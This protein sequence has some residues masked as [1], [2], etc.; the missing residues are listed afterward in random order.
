MKLKITLC[1]LILL[2]II[3]TTPAQTIATPPAVAAASGQGNTWVVSIG[4][5]K[6]EHAP[7]LQYTLADAKVFADA[8]SQ[9]GLVPESN[10][11]RI[12]DGLAA[13]EKASALTKLL[14]QRMQSAGTADTFI[15]FFAGHGFT[16]RD[17]TTYLAL[18]DFDPK[19][20]SETGLSTRQLR[21][22][23]D[24]CPARVK[25]VILDSCFSGGFSAADRIDGQAVVDQLKRARGTVAICSS[26]SKQESLEASDLGHGVFTYWLNR[27]LRGEANTEID[28][29]IDSA[30]LFRFVKDRVMKMASETQQH[31][32][33]PTWGFDQMAEIPTVIELRRPDKPSVL[34][35][36]KQMPIGSDEQSLSA[37]M[38]VLEKFPQANVR[39]TIGMTK[40]IIA[41]AS[42]SSSVAKRA[43]QHLDQL[44]A[45]LLN[46]TLRLPPPEP[47]E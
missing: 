8:F 24:E 41:N 4:V 3:T 45:Q 1:F 33:Q 18:A 32:Q 16:D 5:G 39:N 27:G 12:A 36:M 43:Q 19:R 13:A 40:W 46:G 44:D 35:P 42:S 34:V 20:A 30:E 9:V 11:N 25:F 22:L 14:T 37:V 6:Y 17:G 31:Q 47:N 15:L 7:S 29:V 23:L 38:D 26:T 21:E 28:N 10:I 2:A